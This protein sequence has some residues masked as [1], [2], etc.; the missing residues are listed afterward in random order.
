MVQ[1]SVDR[2]HSHIGRTPLQMKHSPLDLRVVGQLLFAP[3]P[4]WRCR[5]NWLQTPG[6]T[7]WTERAKE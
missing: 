1:P 2:P 3:F 7:G 5:P 6:N 4:H